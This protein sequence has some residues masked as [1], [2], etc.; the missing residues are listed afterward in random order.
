MPFPSVQAIVQS[1]RKTVLRFPLEVL[2]AI[3]GTICAEIIIYRGGEPDDVLLTATLCSFLGISVF[4]AA[5]LV[6]ESRHAGRGPR[7]GLYAAGAVL[8]AASVFSVF[9]IT[10]EVHVIRFLLLGAAFHLAVSV[11]PR[12]E[13]NGFWEFNKL[14]FLRLLLAQLYA[15]VLF[16]GLAIALATSNYLFGWN[17]TEKIYGY[18]LVFVMGVFHTLFFLSGVPA[19]FSSLQPDYPRPLKLFTQYV[20]IP[21]AVLYLAII[22]VYEVNVVINWVLPKGIIATLI[23]GYG[24]YGILSLLLVFPVRGQAGNQWI[25]TFSRLFY[26]LLFPLIPLLVVAIGV[27]AGHYGI[28]EPRYLVMITAAWLF[29]VTVYYLFVDKDNIR[30][31]PV[32]LMVVALISAW[33]PQ[34]ATPVSRQS[35]QARLVHLFRA[36]ALW[37]NGQLQPV[38]FT[39]S[40]STAQGLS[41]QI[42]YLVQRYGIRSVN[43]MVNDSIGRQLLAADTLV[44]HSD[45]YHRQIR[46]LENAL[47]LSNRPDTRQSFAA[48]AKADAVPVEG[49]R[50]M[51][52]IDRLALNDS[53]LFQTD[54]LVI[55]FD[56][57]N[58]IRVPLRAV[59]NEIEQSPPAE[60]GKQE[61]E[62]A[63]LRAAGLTASGQ[64]VV[65]QLTDIRYS[66]TAAQR[67]LSFV[68][69]Y[70][71]YR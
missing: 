3:A 53:L 38:P 23:L 42:R 4:L 6:A 45:R 61:W 66:K 40:D 24:V 58:P 46:I 63:H 2:C 49:Y 10:Q 56:A 71:L 14:I 33:G 59:L 70:V 43:S 31:I 60:A 67:S 27:R 15:W 52:E 55:F 7:A 16:A 18:L 36:Q 20:L 44:S 48:R 68:K 17:L 34:S 8:L 29:V 12:V 1:I 64:P 47:S 39:V 25:G 11:A 19:G 32:S 57:G 30:F 9:P 54:T 41:G 22:L 28:T 51:E 69:G 13:V 26:F 50:W 65:L 21:L 62:P 37:K 35:Q 5:T